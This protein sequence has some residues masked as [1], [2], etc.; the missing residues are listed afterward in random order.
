MASAAASARRKT[1][2]DLRIEAEMKTPSGLSMANMPSSSSASSGGGSSSTIAVTAVNKGIFKLELKE[3]EDGPAKSGGTQQQQQ[4]EKYTESL[5]PGRTLQRNLSFDLKEE[6]NHVL[7]VTVAYYEKTETSGKMRTFRKLYQ[8]LCKG[9]I[10]VRTKCTVLRV[11]WL[12]SGPLSHSLLS[13]SESPDSFPPLATPYPSLEMGKDERKEEIKGQEEIIESK[14]ITK[15]HRRQE[16]AKLKWILEAQLENCTDSIMQLDRITLEL[17]PGLR[18]R[19]CLSWDSSP[20]AVS[21]SFPTC[22]FPLTTVGCF[23]IGGKME[24]KPVLHPMEIEQVAFIVEEDT[25][26]TEGSDKNEKLGAPGASPTAA[27]HTMPDGRL[28]FGMLGIGWQ[29]EMGNRGF[30]NT[31]RLIV[32]LK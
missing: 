3:P 26:K 1:I 19:S 31:G 28:V 5:E 23:S 11:P 9:S 13:R 18:A 21:S 15:R 22:A 8:F 7:A 20:G 2:S 32:N 24:G 29:N 17:I 30:L 27:V 16:K 10:T 4:P 25:S 12:E 14:K 6:G